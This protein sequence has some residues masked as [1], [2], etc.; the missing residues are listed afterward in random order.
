MSGK[1]KN[2]GASDQQETVTQATEDLTRKVTELVGAVVG[3][4][5]SVAKSA[6]QATSG[7]QPIQE[8]KTS[9][10]SL[11]LMIHYG[12]TAA[13][14]IIRTA[15][16]AGTRKAAAGSKSGAGPAAGVP[17][18]PSVI[19]GSTLRVPL[20]IENSD[21]K[22]MNSLKFQCLRVEALEVGRG[23]KL[24]VANVKLS[25]SVLSIPPRDF[26]K[27]TVFVETKP[28]TALGTYLAVIG[29][30]AGGLETPLQF[31]VLPPAKGVDR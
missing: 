31:E 11:N 13:T 10:G 27:L 21:A 7:G 25:P 20:S 12:V 9:Q 24:G 28:A 17:V 30:G 16:S 1:A 29:V 8:P 2:S 4:G 3:L 22:P 14:N 18:G 15:V 6:A 5:A 19:A 23:Q 26:E